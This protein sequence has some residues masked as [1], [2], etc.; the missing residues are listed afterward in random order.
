MI[1][2]KGVIPAL[3]TPFT[4]DQALDL[5]GFRDL[6]DIV[7]D[8][9]VHGILVNGCTG[10]SWTFDDKERSV[11][12]G[13][14][15]NQTGGRVPVLAGC[16]A[17]CAKDAI[18]KVR[19]AEKAG[20]DAVMIQ[21]PWYVLISLEEVYEYYREILDAIDMPVMIYNIPRRTGINLSVDLVDRLADEPKVVALKE[22]SK[23][24]LLL[25]A[26]IRRVKDRI[27]VFSGYANLLG[28][29]AL[30]EGAVGYVDSSAPVLGKRSLE[31]F[32]AAT[33]GD[34]EKARCL[35]AK[36][37]TLNAGFFGVGTFPAGIKAA[38]DMLDRPGGWPRD[39]IKPLNAAQQNQIKAVLISAGLLQPDTVQSVVA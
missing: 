29:A 8:D 16:G 4:K 13:V 5:E 7:I 33:A 10:E 19:Q 24:W 18:A 28:L 32:N 23:D 2:L 3:T 38:L 22:S 12:F 1:A 30:T 14:A 15:V 39:P 37:A 17:I 20:C 36:M 27:H 34:L 26:M 25:S 6:I 35:Q 31:F 21:P 9:G 11:M